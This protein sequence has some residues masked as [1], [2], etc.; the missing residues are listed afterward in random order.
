MQWFKY[1]TKR[2]GEETFDHK[3]FKQS[4]DSG[5]LK[6]VFEIS[7]QCTAR[8]PQ[9]HR[10]N[11][12]EGQFCS[13]EEWLPLVYW[14]LKKWKNALGGNTIPALQHIY[15]CGTYGDANTCKDLPQ[16]IEYVHEECRKNK[17]WAKR[18]IVDTNG[19]NRT[20]EWWA[21]LG[22]INKKSLEYSGKPGLELVFAI[23]GITQSM[24]SKYR[25]GTN[26]DK[27]LKNIKAYVDAGGFALTNTI[28]FKHNQDYLKD[29]MN[30]TKDHGVSFHIFHESDRVEMFDENGVYTFY[31]EE[32]NKQTLEMCDSDIVLKQLEDEIERVKIVAPNR[33]VYYSANG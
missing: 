9:C 18:I 1:D 28:V 17:V 20:P 33:V 32:N 3:T 19:S 6:P 15:V 23:D 24:H 10:T 2:A 16:M 11:E 14:N 22:E 21:K 30:M 7:T 8:C 29:I 12:K 13:K 25:R 5:Y 4:F 27:I 26:L 31:D